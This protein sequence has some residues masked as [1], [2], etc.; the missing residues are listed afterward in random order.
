MLERGR[1]QPGD[2][3]LPDPGLPDPRVGDLPFQQLEVVERSAGPVR[4]L[5]L[6]SDLRWG[7]GPQ[8]L[9]RTSRGEKVRSYPATGT[10]GG[11]DAEA[12]NPVSSAW[13]R[14]GRP[15]CRSKT[16]VATWGAD[17][18]PLLRRDRSVP[19]PTG[20]RL[21]WSL[22]A[23]GRPPAGTSSRANTGNGRPSTPPP[24]TDG[25]RLA[26]ARGWRPSPNSS[27][28]CSSDTT[29]PSARSSPSRPAPTHLPGD[30]PFSS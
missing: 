23:L 25:V 1:D 2:R 13:S 20:W 26:R 14:G 15:C 11:R 3:D 10:C 28:I 8:G 7:D 30:S 12:R 5:D 22:N 27:R 19:H 17:A 18:G 9:R 21:L 16:S 29:S 4:G 24:A 6:S